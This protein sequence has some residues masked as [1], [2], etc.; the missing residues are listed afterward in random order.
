MGLDDSTGAASPGFFSA[1]G[2]QL[3]NLLAGDTGHS[4]VPSA[5]AKNFFT[6][7]ATDMGHQA[8][9]EEQNRLSAEFGTRNDQFVVKNRGQSKG[10][11]QASQDAKGRSSADTKASSS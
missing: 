9:D 3:L 4:E 8:N 6:S 7:K 10:N 5:Q 11:H 2:N 1:L